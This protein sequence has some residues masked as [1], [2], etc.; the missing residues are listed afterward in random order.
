VE[1]KPLAQALYKTVAI[2]KP[3]PDDLFQAVAEILAYVFGS[4]KKRG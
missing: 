4:R 1:N 3:I 2:N